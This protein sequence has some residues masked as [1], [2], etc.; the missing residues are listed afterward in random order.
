[1][2]R[3]NTGYTVPID[4]IMITNAQFAIIRALFDLFQA[5][6]EDLDLIADEHQQRPYEAIA[7]NVQ[8]TVEGV[9]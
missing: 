4:E 5:I 8:Q 3:W 1:M 6:S 9:N 2:K 7:G